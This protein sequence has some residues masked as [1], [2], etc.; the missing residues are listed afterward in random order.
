MMI[1]TNER[2]P[3]MI[4]T[5]WFLFALL[6]ALLFAGLSPV[7]SAHAADVERSVQVIETRSGVQFGIWGDL[8][9]TPSPTLIVLAGTIDGTLS[10]AYF[11]QA[12]TALTDL[13]Y[14]CVSVDLPCHGEQQRKDEPGGLS[15]WRHRC[16][17]SD[18]FVAETNKRLAQVLDHLIEG[19]HTDAARVAACGTSRG[20]FLALHF[21]AYDPRVKCVAAYAPVTELAAL[22]EFR[23]AE[24]NAL[25]QSLALSQ[26]A[27]KLADRK[28]WVIIGDRDE[29]VGTDRA[30][31]LARR[32]TK[33]ALA[34]GHDGRV[35]LHV[36]T[37]PRGHMTP[38]GAAA[39]SADWIRRQFE[40]NPPPIES[41]N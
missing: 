38:A 21:A 27:E 39:Q 41:R 22:S 16:E 19:R 32:I 28:V 8:P 1:S 14:L 13:G 10:S 34:H 26:Q 7:L 35:D 6:F 4:R 20:G 31:T 37:E 9:A 23:G 17:Q 40:G 24:D 18:D 11:R 5:N 15:G 2:H 33:A 12:G 29:R 3:T 25:V 30:I 36:V